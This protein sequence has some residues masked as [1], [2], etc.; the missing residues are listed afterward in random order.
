[1][2]RS[3]APRSMKMAGCFS[4][5]AANRRTSC[6][7]HPGHSIFEP[8]IK[9]GP[10]RRLRFFCHNPFAKEGD[11]YCQSGKIDAGPVSLRVF[12]LRI[13]DGIDFC[14]VAGWWSVEED[15]TR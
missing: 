14:R 1:M 8:D 11:F 6:P 5:P 2:P 13:A 15:G 9:H 4:W 3:G 12:E 10:V 7:G